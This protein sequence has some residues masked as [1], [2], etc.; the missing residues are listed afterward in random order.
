VEAEAEA[1]V[2][3]SIDAPA[4]AELRFAARLCL[5]A[6]LLA[7]ENEANELLIAA[8]VKL[9]LTEWSCLDEREAPLRRKEIF[10]LCRNRRL[11]A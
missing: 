2:V 9:L 6:P 11:I 5:D 3:M 4:R 7:R 8:L 1:I 10:G